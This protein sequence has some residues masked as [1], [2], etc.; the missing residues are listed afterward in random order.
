[1]SL[2]QRSQTKVLQNEKNES[3]RGHINMWY[4]SIQ[5]YLLMC[6]IEFPHY[7]NHYRSCKL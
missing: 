7:S 1:M 2:G 6:K 4:F 3:G 5:V